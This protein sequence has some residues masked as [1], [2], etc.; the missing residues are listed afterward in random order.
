M[1]KAL[2]AAVAAYPGTS[3]H[4]WGTAI[5]VPERPCEYGLHTPQRDWLV[6][7]GARFGWYPIASEYW[8]F[9]YRP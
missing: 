3:K 8:H 1:Y 2:G 9:E 4:G 7:N 5:D 6:A